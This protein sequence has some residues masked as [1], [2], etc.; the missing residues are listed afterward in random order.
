ME[1]RDEKDTSGN[2]RV[3]SI[4]ANLPRDLIVD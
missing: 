2:G 1:G 4:F 3:N